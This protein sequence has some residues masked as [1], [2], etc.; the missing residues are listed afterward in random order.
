[1]LTNKTTENCHPTIRGQCREG[2]SD[3]GQ[4]HARPGKQRQQYCSSAV[5][6][7]F[8]GEDI[9]PMPSV[10]RV[11]PKCRR[12]LAL[13]TLAK[14]TSRSNTQRYSKMLQGAKHRRHPKT[15]VY[16]IHLGNAFYQ[17]WYHRFMCRSVSDAPESTQVQGGRITH[18]RLHE[19]PSGQ[20]EEM[21][22]ARL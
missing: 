17:S 9:L 7:S 6:E 8:S 19:F 21:S 15:W 2:F 22:D 13:V 18:G 1:M 3:Y 12:F 14:K 11:T 5:V 16:H 20:L 10:P 4:H